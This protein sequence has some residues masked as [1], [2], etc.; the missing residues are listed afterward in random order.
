VAE[1]VKPEELK[2]VNEDVTN[3][4]NEGPQSSVEVNEISSK[5]AKSGE[6]DDQSNVVMLVK[7]L[8]MVVVLLLTI[9]AI[10]YLI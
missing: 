10:L 4:A 7:A 3:D 1:A 5:A 9:D 8:A 2:L 6:E